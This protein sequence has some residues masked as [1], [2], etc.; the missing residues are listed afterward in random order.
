MKKYASLLLF[1][2]LLNGCDDGDLKVDTIDFDEVTSTSCDTT[3]TLVY[4]LKSQEALLL[5]MLPKSIINEDKDTIVYDIDNTTYRVLYRAYNGE[6]SRENICGTIPPKTPSVTEEW[7]G[8]G[9]QIQII[10][11][12]VYKTPAPPDGHT[13]IVGYNH[14][15]IFKNITFSKPS[16]PQVEAEYPFGDFKTEITPVI[17]SFLEADNAK[18]CPE[19]KKVFNNNTSNSLVIENFDG[20]NLIKNEDTPTGFPRTSLINLNATTNNLYYRTYNGNLPLAANENYYCLE[21]TPT[22][23]TV[24]STW[25]GVAG[26]TNV[27]GIIEVTTTSNLKVFKHQIVLKNATLKKGNNTFKL[28]T[29]FILG[30]VTTIAP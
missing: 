28:A 14:N 11:G 26:V 6:V 10:T 21:K 13:E 19:F 29:N 15:I 7:V 2:L 12:A 4:K 30:T 20:T 1:A 25:V 3:N 23:P 17:V 8:T 22:S 18:Y 27:S 9:G 16:G 24:Q 5:Q